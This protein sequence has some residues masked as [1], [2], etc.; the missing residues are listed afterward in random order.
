M[1]V[2]ASVRSSPPPQGTLPQRPALEHVL[3]SILLA[4]EDVL[5]GEAR[6]GAIGRERDERSILSIA[7]NGA[8]GRYEDQERY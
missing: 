2:F 3:P 5:L 8:I 4:L 6:G 1:S 7:T